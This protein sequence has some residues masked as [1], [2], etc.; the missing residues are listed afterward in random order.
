MILG[1]FQLANQIQEVIVRGN[2]L[3][4][5]ENGMITSVEGLKISKSGVIKEFPDL[6]DKD[7]WRKQ[8]IERLKN[9]IKTMN[10][11]EKRMDYVKD[12][13]KKQGYKPLFWQK[14]GW[15]PQKFK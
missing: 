1:T 14:S 4:F 9:H 12:E 3:L 2:E 10:T 15:R 13:L 5:S 8:A 7:D 11:E 6:T